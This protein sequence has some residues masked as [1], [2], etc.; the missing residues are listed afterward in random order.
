MGSVSRFASRISVRLTEEVVEHSLGTQ[1]QCAHEDSR[2]PDC[3]E[4]HQVHTL[5]LSFFEQRMDPAGITPLDRS[6][7]R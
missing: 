5:V 4:T 2:F 6:I 3:E 1:N 7:V